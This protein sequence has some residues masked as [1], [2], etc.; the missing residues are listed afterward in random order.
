MSDTFSS[1]L[2]KEMENS[3]R[4]G[5]NEEE[6]EGAVVT[7]KITVNYRIVPGLRDKSQ[8]LWAYEEDQ[9]YYKNTSHTSKKR[10][11]IG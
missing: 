9:L 1:Q 8:L 2:L 7:G 11:T 5:E 10:G 3:I 6:D 4:N